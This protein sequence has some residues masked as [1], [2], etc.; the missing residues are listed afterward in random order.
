MN[1]Q[2]VSGDWKILKGKIKTAWG[3]LTDDDID[4]AEG[5]LNELEGKI[6]KAY[7]LTKEEATKKFNEFRNSLSDR[8]NPGEEEINRTSYSSDVNQ[9]SPRERDTHH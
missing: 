4:S 3:K 2:T 5:N 7:G 9:P 6:Q 1:K 8:S